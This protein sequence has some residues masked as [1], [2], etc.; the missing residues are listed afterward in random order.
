MARM[1]PGFFDETTPPGEVDV[2]RVLA[3]GPQDW[4]VLH[5]L[6]LARE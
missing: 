1:I 6:D 4:V 2:F 3:K 5:S